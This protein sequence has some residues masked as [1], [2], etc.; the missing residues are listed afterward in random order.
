MDIKTL[1]D[2]QLKMY[3]TG[4]IDA[5]RQQRKEMELGVRYYNGEQEILRKDRKSVV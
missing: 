2:E 5:Y 4:K 1:S 3:I